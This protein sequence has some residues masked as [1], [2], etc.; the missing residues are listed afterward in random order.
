VT[1]EE[2]RK[3]IEALIFAAPYPLSAKEI[4]EIIELDLDTVNRIVALIKD[5]YQESGFILRKVAEGYQF[6][7]RPELAPWIEKLGRPIIT[8]PLSA[9]AL[10]TL[11]II[12]YQQPITRSEIEQIRGVNSESAINTLIE[13]ELVTELGRREGLGR[14]IIYGTTD[15]FLLEFNLASL[16][17]LPRKEEFQQLVNPNA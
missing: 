9:A 2:A 14:P 7:T 6:V 13:R 10:E 16:D 4:S 3:I 1:L 12:A 15:K 17:D 5:R 11:A 8:A